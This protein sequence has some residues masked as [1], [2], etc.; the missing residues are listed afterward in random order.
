MKHFIVKKAIREMVIE[1]GEY[2]NVH[3][4]PLPRTKV[5]TL[6]FAYISNNLHLIEEFVARSLG[7]GTV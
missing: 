5:E 3:A 7:F 1:F 2:N 6:S 4:R